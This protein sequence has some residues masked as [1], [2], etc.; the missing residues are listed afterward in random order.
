MATGHERLRF[1]VWHIIEGEAEG[2]FSIAALVVVAAVT[3]LLASLV[4]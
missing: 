2:R 1:K 3:A 4:T